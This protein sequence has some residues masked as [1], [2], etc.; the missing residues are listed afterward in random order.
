LAPCSRAYYW[1]IVHSAVVLQLVES[2][3]TALEGRSSKLKEAVG[4]LL[5]GPVVGAEHFRLFARIL[6]IE[7][8]LK[9]SGKGV[10][11][12][13]TRNIRHISHV[14]FR[15]QGGVL[16]RMSELFVWFE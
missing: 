12:A 11:F 13:S 3:V 2:R 4:R 14:W 6:R 16:E 8:S 15:K 1:H 9:V 7:V 5:T 10:V